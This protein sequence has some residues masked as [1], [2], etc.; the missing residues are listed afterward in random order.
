MIFSTNKVDVQK[1][2]G[3]GISKAQAQFISGTNNFYCFPIEAGRTYKITTTPK[4]GAPTMKW[5]NS[6]QSPSI[7]V[8]IS[9][10]DS[11]GGVSDTLS[12]E[13]VATINGYHAIEI[14][15]GKDVTIEVAFVV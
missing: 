10:Y 3:L 7:G 5:C 1:I 12:R 2:A 13:L 4:E 15:D 14:L 9:D 8:L 11:G 6:S